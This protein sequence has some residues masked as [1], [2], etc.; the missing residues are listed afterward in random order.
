MTNEEI[1]A[2]LTA[3]GEYAITISTSEIRS[4][5]G[6]DTINYWAVQNGQLVNIDQRWV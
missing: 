5:H 3:R 1:I 4:L 6:R 2:A